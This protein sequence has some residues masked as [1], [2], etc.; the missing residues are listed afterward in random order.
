MKRCEKLVDIQSPLMGICL[1]FTSQQ[2][3][4]LNRVPQ[5]DWPDMSMCMHVIYVQLGCVRPTYIADHVFFLNTNITLCQRNFETNFKT[6]HYFK[7]K[8]TPMIVIRVNSSK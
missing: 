7:I 2:E 8:L 5:Y 4:W 1:P 6:F 3:D